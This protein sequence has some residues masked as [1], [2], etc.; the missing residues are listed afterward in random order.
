M[1]AANLHHDFDPTDSSTWPV[2][3]DREDSDPP[4]RSN[5]RHAPGMRAGSLGRILDRTGELDGD[6]PEQLASWLEVDLSAALR[7]DKV[8]PEPTILR[9]SDGRHLFY[10]GQINY[11]HGS[12][13]AGKSFVALFAAKD[14]LDEGDH[15]VW[16]DWEDP[17][18]AT[19]IGRLLDLGVDAQVI[20]ERFH[21]FHPESEATP[22]AVSMICD[23]V[24][25]Y[26][27]RLVVVDSVGE[28]LGIDGINEDKD[29]EV[30]PWIR[31]VLRPLAGTGAGV[32]PIDHGVKNGDNPLHPSGSKRKRATVTGAHYLVEAP[33]PL[34][35]EMNG[36]QLR[37]T[38]AKD[39]HGHYTRG[40]AAAIIDVAIYPDGGWTVHVH[41]PA[42]AGTDT[43]DPADIIAARSAI[44]AC[45]DIFT[46]TGTAASM[47]ALE[48][49]MKLKGRATVKRAG[50]EYA[51]NL[52]CLTETQ[53]PRNARLYTYV[54]DL[55]A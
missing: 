9:R 5:G 18:E 6:E 4:V 10:E 7:G 24:R 38:T 3:P 50:I 44:K 48:S 27:A 35:A 23:A 1:A 54:K 52:G 25:R 41:P 20:G 30:T 19:V 42:A 15:V 45:R 14:V 37:L 26:G 12:D 55:D 28:A 49:R 43:G 17:D 46:E 22:T 13:G 2:A 40:K 47:N 33:K 34:S 53:G 36:G 29:N 21:Y 11:L 39:R 51:T 32:L 16:L 8:R 31:R